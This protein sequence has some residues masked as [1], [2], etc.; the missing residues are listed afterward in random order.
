MEGAIC[1]YSEPGKG[2]TFKIL[3]PVVSASDATELPAQLVL[4]PQAAA[5]HGFD[6]RCAIVVGDKPCDVDLGHA[7]GARSFLVRSGYGLTFEAS[8]NAH[9]VVDDIPAVAAYLGK[10]GE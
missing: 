7:I 8:T 3:I 9:A 10:P 6:S 5:E 2:S 4:L 1:V